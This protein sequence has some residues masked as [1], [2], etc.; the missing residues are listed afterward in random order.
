MANN[1]NPQLNMD[2]MRDLLSPYLDGEITGEE[3]V[4]VEQAL[5]ASPEL[6]RELESL[7]RTIT[8]VAALPPIPAPRPF[9]LT[10][11]VVHP[12]TPKSKGF[13]GLPSWAMGW[14][15]LAATLLCVLIA[16]GLF[17]TMQFGGGKM[18][19]MA[20]AEIAVAP[21]HTA[22][23]A[24]EAPAA[25]EPTEEPA[26]KKEVPTEA[27]AEAPVLELA[28]P[29][30]AVTEEDRGAV[31]VKPAADEAA[32]EAAPQTVE[33]TAIDSRQA[34]TE[35][36]TTGSASGQNTE[37]YA[38][39]PMAVAPAPTP[40]PQPTLMTFAAPAATEEQLMGAA[41][42]EP[43]QPAPESNQAPAAAA[44]PEQELLKQEG[45]AQPPEALPTITPLPTA[46]LAPM[47]T[48]PPTPPASPTMVALL[49]LP[50]PLTPTLTVAAV[51][52]TSPPDSNWLISMGIILVLLA[53]LVIGLFMGIKR[54]KGR[55]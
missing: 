22:M 34:I 10:E 16:G 47:P 29:A 21:A 24:A 5:A 51:G 45:A 53:L 8:M 30:P 19:A 49:T 52:E 3:Q 36:E 12:S 17:W 1:N 27:P 43:G 31:A 55:S 32:G 14:A 9:T 2:Q 48:Q 11:A 23:L 46:T 38:A 18:P 13:L 44:Q 7:R 33:D 4:L 39:P 41:Q 26:A 15:T 42:A 20:P 40:S 50:A 25:E 54:N 37:G 28:A 35:A 6:R